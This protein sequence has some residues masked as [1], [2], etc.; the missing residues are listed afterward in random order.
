MLRN[1][2]R[3][4]V[5]ITSRENL[6]LV[7]ETGT[8]KTTLVQELSRLLGKELKVFNVSQSTDSTDLL[9]G[10]KPVDVKRR[11]REIYSSFLPVF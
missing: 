11:M 6:L 7:G 2:E 5:G 9:G 8:G 4:L 10:Y 1:L 3:V